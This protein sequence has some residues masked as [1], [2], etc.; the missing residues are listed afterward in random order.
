M[1]N[2]RRLASRR[3]IITT[4]HHTLYFS[5]RD[6]LAATDGLIFRG[7]RLVIPKG[8]RAAVKKDIYNGHQRIE[9]C[10]RCTREHVYWPGMNKNLKAWIRTCETCR[11]NELTPC[12]ETLMSHE[13][14]E[15]AW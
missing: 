2:T 3:V 7:E 8:M 5:V 1:H 4:P 10:L 9:S 11:G 14:P 13:I 15:G 6:E 12:K